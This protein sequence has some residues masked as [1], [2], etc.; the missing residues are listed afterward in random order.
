MVQNKNNNLKKLLGLILIVI[1]ISFGSCEK[2]NCQ[3]V[4]DPNCFCTEQYEPVC[5]C[6][7]ITYGNDCMAECEGIYTYTAGPCQ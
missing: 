7:N 5:G 6:N 2:N 3:A 1:A 4:S